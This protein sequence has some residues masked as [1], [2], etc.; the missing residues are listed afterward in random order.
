MLR[1]TLIGL[2]RPVVE[3]LGYTLWD[4][5]Y[6]PGRGNSFVRLYID[7]EPGITLDD[8]ERVSREVSELLDAADPVPGQYTLEVSSPGLDR[9]LRTA[10][11]FAPYVGETVFVELAHPLDGRRRYK[12]PLRAAGA[13]TVE[14]EVDG[15]SYVL[16]ISGIR[17]AH[18][19]PDA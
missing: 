8:C 5:E 7:A 16:P 3:G 9:P 11:H 1:D 15:R 14:V 10:A 6:S 13:E 17:K 4:L 19:A 12:G 18:L 2:V